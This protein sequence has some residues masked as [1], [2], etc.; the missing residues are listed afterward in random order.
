MDEKDSLDTVKKLSKKELLEMLEEM[1]KSY[2]KLP[3]HAMFS[4]PSNSDLASAL[5]LVLAVF[6]SED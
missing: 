4:Y 6:R 5:M 2:E 1:I 3:P